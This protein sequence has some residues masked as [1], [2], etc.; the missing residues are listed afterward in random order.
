M[1][2]T[3]RKLAVAGA[4]LMA[5]AAAAFAEDR[6]GTIDPNGDHPNCPT[7]QPNC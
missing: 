4:L 3:M 6:G 1:G 7:G 5:L 2:R